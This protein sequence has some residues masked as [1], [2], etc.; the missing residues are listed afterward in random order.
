LQASSLRFLDT[1]WLS[2]ALDAGW[3][4]A[5]L[6]SCFPD[7]RYEVMCRRYDCQGLVVALSVGM[8]CSIVSIDAGGIVMTR[9]R[10]EARLLRPR[11]MPGAHMARLWWEV[12]A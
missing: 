7:R 2:A 8:G 6:W 4:E 11:R 10:T 3:T 5:E 12:A 1:P 9:K